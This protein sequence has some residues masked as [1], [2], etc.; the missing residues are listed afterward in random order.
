MIG[1]SVVFGLVCITLYNI[2]I[3][4]LIDESKFNENFNYRSIS[5]G[6]GAEDLN[7]MQLQKN[8]PL[9][10]NIVLN[11]MGIS[12]HLPMSLR[13]L[14]GD[15]VDKFMFGEDEA[16]TKSPWN[17]Y[18]YMLSPG[19]LASQYIKVFFDTN[20]YLSL[21]LYISWLFSDLEFWLELSMFLS[22][23][24]IL[25]VQ[26][27][28]VRLVNATIVAFLLFLSHSYVQ[29]IGSFGLEDFGGVIVFFLVVFTLRSFG[30]YSFGRDASN[31][32]TYTI[33]IVI[34]L[35][36]GVCFHLFSSHLSDTIFSVS[37]FAT[38]IYSLY[39]IKSYIDGFIVLFKDAKLKRE[40]VDPEKAATMKKFLLSAKPDTLWSDEAFDNLYRVGDTTLGSGGFGTVKLGT[41]IATNE[42]VAIKYLHVDLN[43]NIPHLCAGLVKCAL[44]GQRKNSDK[45]KEIL[46]SN[47]LAAA[48]ID[49]NMDVKYLLHELQTN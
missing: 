5:R 26:S 16:S 36:V 17:I 41:K 35:L 39:K 12:P 47:L 37:L 24:Y 29:G 19:F 42:Q 30:A 13:F 28:L 7:L 31:Q 21:V 1:I 38:P 22:G 25:A 48:K 23:Y 18:L 4:K 11:T 46:F 9:S 2:N 33:P 6:T 32:N 43:F 44:E 40:I 49:Y 34:G 45:I 27:Y 20:Y 15:S 14:Y 3:R 10:C 8:S